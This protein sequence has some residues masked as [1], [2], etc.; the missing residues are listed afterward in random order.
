M[1]L[2]EILRKRAHEK[3]IGKV[4]KNNKAKLYKK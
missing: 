3:N 1:H 4:H 2:H